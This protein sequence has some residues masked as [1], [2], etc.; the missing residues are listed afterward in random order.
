MDTNNLLW[1]LG[2]KIPRLDTDE[3]YGMVE[4]TSPPHVPGPPPHFHKRENEFFFVIHGT[5]EV[6][7]N[8]KGKNALREV[9]LNSA[10]EEGL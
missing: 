6:M 5:L 4:I 3:S 1:A 8:V 2:H 10:S 9:S 7:T